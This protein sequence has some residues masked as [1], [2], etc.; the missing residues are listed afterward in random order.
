MLQLYILH[1]TLYPSL[2]KGQK[3]FLYKNIREIVSCI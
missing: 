2:L 1:F 3:A